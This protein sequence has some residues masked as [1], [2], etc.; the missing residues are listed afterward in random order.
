MSDFRALPSVDSVMRERALAPYS[1]RVRGLAAKAAI[2][3]AR[4]LIRAGTEQTAESVV[5]TAA[6][7]A[8]SIAKATLAPAINMSGVVLHTGLGRAR[9]SASAAKEIAAVAEN[10]ATVE[11]DMP[12]GKRG[13]R[14]DHVRS[15]IC[16][17]TGAEDAFVVNNCAAA[18]VLVLAALCRG[19]EVILSR[20][21]MI[22]I[23]GSFRLP[24]IVEASGCKLVEV[25]STNKT[26]LSDYSRAF[27]DET[28]AILRCHP[29][30]FKI[31]GFHE[32]QSAHDLSG[33]CKEHGVLLIDDVGSGCLV[34]TTRFGLPKEQTLR[35]V[36]SA[37]ADVVMS[38]GDKLLGGPQAGLVMGRRDLIAQISRHP[39]ARA[40]RVGKMTLAGLRATLELYAE[41]REMEI[42]IWRYIAKDQSQVKKAANRI[43][44]AWSGDAVVEKA[45]TEVGGGSMPTATVPTWRVGLKSDD[46]DALL[47]RLRDFDPPVIGYIADGTVWLDP[48]TAD[49]SEVATVV[50]H[51]RAMGQ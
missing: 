42:P 1:E 16:E 49:D 29:S 26:H 5:E 45:G 47:G 37:G 31:V 41:G 50:D 14:Q 11:F 8:E 33:I 3:S 25:G 9:L 27:G 19:R 51:F 24:D 18:V 7:V 34:D 4:E 36:I 48:R 40:L 10:H 38:S 15:L 32:E 28:A 35:E 13:N 44:K 46:A 6:Q 12:T 2:E 23:G 17:L 39:L 22:E 20:G 43:A 21:Q 30:N